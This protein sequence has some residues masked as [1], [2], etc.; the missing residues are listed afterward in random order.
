M[1]KHCRHESDV[2]NV[3]AGCVCATQLD[4]ST[5]KINFFRLFRVMRLVKLLNR[6]EGIRTLLWTFVKSFQVRSGSLFLYRHGNDQWC[7][8]DTWWKTSKI[9]GAEIINK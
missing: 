7:A 5:I 6:G 4:S 1:V 2:V 3:G 8:Q 9:S